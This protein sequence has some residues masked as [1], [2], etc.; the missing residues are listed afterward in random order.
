MNNLLTKRR[1]EHRTF[2]LVNTIFLL[3]TQFHNTEFTVYHKI[4]RDGMRKSI[5]SNSW[6][7]KKFYNFA[8]EELKRHKRINK[9]NFHINFHVILNFQIHFVDS[10][11]KKFKLFFSIFEISF[12]AWTFYNR[13][14]CC[15]A[16]DCSRFR[17]LDSQSHAMISLDIF[18]VQK[19]R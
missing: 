12:S 17:K 11:I 10:H 5:F 3:S 8:S 7:H 9:Q 4:H 19:S 6:T 1:H 16:G 18:G 15:S 14:S 13:W 2:Q